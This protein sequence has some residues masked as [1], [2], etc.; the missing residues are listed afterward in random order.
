MP[1][2]N[3]ED[4]ADVKDR[5]DEFFAARAEDRAEVLRRLFVEVLDFGP[6]SGQLDLHSNTA[7]VLLPS[8]AERIAE[9]DG[10][11]VLF[12][13]LETAR[14][15]K[16]EAAAV[17]RIVEPE[18]GEQMLLLLNNGAADQLHLIHPR[19][20]GGATPKL[21][22]L[23]FDRDGHNRTSLGQTANLYWRYQQSHNL[24]SALE[25]AFNVDKVTRDFFREY[26]KL[27]DNALELV[28]GLDGEERK[29]FVQTL[30]NR[31][32][33]V[34][35]LSRKGWLKYEGKTDY[36]N[37]LWKA[38]AGNPH[39]DFYR[40]RLMPLFFNGLNNPDARNVT[41]G[42]EPLVGQV[43]FLNGGL[44]EKGELDELSE[45]GTVAVPDEAIQP[46]LSDL[47]DK[48]NFT[49][50]ESTPFDVEVAVDPEM[51]GKVF[52]ELVTGRLA[53]G[54]Y[55]TPRSV[56]SFMCREALKGYLKSRL[57]ALP[58]DR[59]SQFV[60]SQDV[61]ALAGVSPMDVL[62]A[63][64]DV[65]VVDPACGSGAFLLGM[66]QELVGLQSAIFDNRLV[67]DE[68]SKYSMK[69]HII[70][71]NLYGADIEEFAVE[72]AKL[73]LWLSLAIDYEGVEPEPL[74]NLDFK[75]AI[76]DSLLGPN[77]TGESQSVLGYDGEEVG[78]LA[79][80][81]S[82]FFNA[83]DGRRK[84][85]LR[86][87]IKVGL[88]HLREHLGLMGTPEEAV[89]WRVDFARPFSQ[90]GFDVLV[91]NPPYAQIKKGVY[92]KQ[93]FPYSE[94]RDRGKQNLYKL[95]VERSY[96][97]CKPGGIATMIVAST[98]MCDLSSAATRELL[99]EQTRLC[100]IIEF[101]KD[102][103]TPSLQVFASVTQGTCIYQFL[104]LSPA[105]DP[106][107]ISIGNDS[108]SIQDPF[109]TPIGFPS[110]KALY[111]NT[112]CFPLISGSSLGVLERFAN[113]KSVRP[114][115]DYIASISQG[116]LNVSTH[117]EHYSTTPTSVHMLRG[118]HIARY[119]VHY[120]AANEFCDEDFRTDYVERNRH[121][122]YL[123][124]QQVTGTTDRRRLHFGLA[125]DPPVD[126]L[127]GHSVNKTNLLDESLGRAFLGILNSRLLDWVF[128]AT[129]SNNNVQGY[130]LEQL[131]I[132]DLAERDRTQLENMVEQIL[133]A[134]EPDPDADTSALEA[135][136]DRIVY[137]L[138]GLT[139]EEIAAVEGRVVS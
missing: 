82:D 135:E 116:D 132:H 112:L 114:L 101:P 22:R 47:F 34:Y 115:N 104:K 21:Q 119:A 51:L 46:L 103:A 25:E 106:L 7:G 68:R 31:L 28:R 17:A 41:L 59:I 125:V 97:L 108:E 73:R 52:E 5:I 40:D 95:F 23:I 61:T 24:L 137:D 99:M 79:S 90:G 53:S 32:M 117:K 123:L 4:A 78:R 75:I 98:L 19:I 56:V 60:E 100:H 87:S 9:L 107:L 122:S 89:E 96:Q 20:D 133:A 113:D 16:R 63:L 11:H 138:Y 26:K 2:L 71:R 36:L 30:F 84:D 72:I 102:A 58:A 44:F 85:Q 48:F 12:V 45:S 69:A 126:Y 1:I 15:N 6:M 110:I 50:M 136:I 120:L 65:T 76:G 93:E 54:A 57:P 66:M 139:E 118:R 129:S 131:P 121:R 86:D 91:G 127:C 13:P 14:I 35:F 94:G 29:Q 130:E 92:S 3:V 49:V 43:P 33:F 109:M 70:E 55:Y 77:P 39:L 111:P 18:L 128:R 74:P 64:E 38:Y 88:H 37:A 81:Q 27:Y 80:M 105:D 67:D 124:S 134:K 62:H 83:T 42:V 10:V 8:S